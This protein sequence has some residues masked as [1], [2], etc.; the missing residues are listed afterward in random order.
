MEKFIG[1]CVR[2]RNQFFVIE[3]HTTLLGNRAWL[4]REVGRHYRCAVLAADARFLRRAE[5]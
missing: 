3:G 2:C 1:R 5:A 4:C